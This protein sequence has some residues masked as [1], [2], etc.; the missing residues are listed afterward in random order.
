VIDYHHR[1]ENVGGVAVFTDVG[2][3]R[4][5]R[6]LARCICTVV[7]VHAIT[8]DGRVI[9]ERRQPPN[10]CVSVVAGFAAGNMR[11]IFADGN[12]AVMAG[13]TGSQYLRVINT[14]HGRK[15]IGGVAILTDTRCLNVCRVLTCRFCTVVTTDT[16]TGDIQVIEVRRQPADRAVTVIAGVAA[17]NM[18][19]LFADGSDTIVAGAAGS[20]YLRVIDG[21]HGRK[22]IR[23]VTVF[24]DV[25]CLNVCWIFANR[26]R[27]V[28]TADAIAGDIDVIEV[29]R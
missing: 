13:A 15:H 8:G 23:R 12:E 26:I 3:Q 11:R 14:H 25:G 4:M 10:R 28:M 20:D 6:V 5:C 17:G 21:Q 19:W 22:H 24:T 2:R 16:V 1:R 29:R 27:A 9:E 18:C 7:A